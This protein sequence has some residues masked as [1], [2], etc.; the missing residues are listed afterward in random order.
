MITVPI[1]LPSNS[2]DLQ[3]VK[4]AS[5]EL[6]YEC[7]LAAATS[8]TAVLHK[9]VRGT[10][11]NVAVASHPTVTQDLTAATDAADEDQHRL[12]VTLYHSRM[13]RQ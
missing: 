4:L 3:G 13:D 9:I 11:T 7:L 12:K 2:V 6:D 1:Q 10:D 8:V 5:I